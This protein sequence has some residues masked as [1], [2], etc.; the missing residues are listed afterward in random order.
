MLTDDQMLELRRLDRAREMTADQ[1]MARLAELGLDPVESFTDGVDYSFFDG[2]GDLIL[3]EDQREMAISVGEEEG[4]MHRR[5][6]MPMEVVQY[7]ELV[8]RWRLDMWTDVVMKMQ[9]DL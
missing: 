7:P 8:E 5:S 6:W 3:L 4:R 2:A 1:I 9:V